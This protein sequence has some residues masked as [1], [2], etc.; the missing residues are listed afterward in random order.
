M[1]N[2]LNTRMVVAV[3]L[4]GA[5]LWARQPSSTDPWES[6]RFLIGRW[7][8]KTQGG[9]AG[10]SSSGTYTFQ[11]ELRDHVLA[12]HADSGPCKG[13]AGF[14]CEHGDLLYVYRDSPG[15]RYKAIYFDNEGHVIHYEVSTPAPGTA[16]FVSDGS[17]PGP[18]FRLVYELR[19][20]VMFGKFEM[21][22]PG[23]TEFRPY[24]E[25][26]GGRK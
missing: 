12:R 21:R 24:L 16:V 18:R 6:L 17:Q 14:D 26:R 11:L 15:Q 9:S 7:E 23:Q 3:L 20:T 1:A 13:P 4:C 25:W 5:G 10:A 19:G 22:V 8:A 2:F